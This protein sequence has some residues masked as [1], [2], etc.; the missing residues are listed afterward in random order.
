MHMYMLDGL[1][2]K[3]FW[4]KIRVLDTFARW[5]KIA[6]NDEFNSEFNK[7]TVLSNWCMQSLA[8]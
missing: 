5:F 6:F 2:T 1:K 3:K 8:D 7:F 4:T